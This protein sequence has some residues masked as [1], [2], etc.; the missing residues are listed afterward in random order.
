MT[1]YNNPD[2]RFVAGFIGSPSM[3]FIAG[4]VKGGKVHAPVLSETPFEANVRL[5]PEGSTVHVGLRPQNV[6]VEPGCALRLDIRERLGGVAYDY[7][8]DDND[9]RIVVETRGDEDI[10]EG[11][12]VSLRFDASDALYF[13]GET[14][15]RL[16]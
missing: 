1:L 14:E 5:P 3:N 10:P 7:L 16:R 8:V 9:A 15:R 4:A 2:N 12:Q 6:S 13:D 11:T